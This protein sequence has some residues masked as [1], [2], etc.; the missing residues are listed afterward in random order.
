MIPFRFDNSLE[1]LTELRKAL[2]LGL[3]CYDSKL[4]FESHPNQQKEEMH[5]VRSGR[6][7]DVKLPLSSPCGVRTHQLSDTS[8]YDD[9]CGTLATKRAHPRFSIQSFIT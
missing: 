5:R 9:T 4:K 3:E 6:V 1:R 8:M 7:P 2:Y